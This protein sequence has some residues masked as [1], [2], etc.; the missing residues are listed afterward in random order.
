VIFRYQLHLQKAQ[1]VTTDSNLFSL[2]AVVMFGNIFSCRNVDVWKS[3]S[4][5]VVKSTSVASFRN[6]P[7]AVDLTRF[8]TVV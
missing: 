7:G 2:A 8:L 5:T 4:D 1:H 6:N 3:L